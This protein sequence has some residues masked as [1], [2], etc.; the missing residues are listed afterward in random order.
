MEIHNIVVALIVFQVAFAAYAKVISQNMVQEENGE[1]TDYSS[2]KRAT[3]KPYCVFSK[4]SKESKFINFLEEVC[5]CLIKFLY[6]LLP[7]DVCKLASGD[8]FASCLRL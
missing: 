2:Y 8:I 1:N 5:Q 4:E 7:L 6:F 3:K